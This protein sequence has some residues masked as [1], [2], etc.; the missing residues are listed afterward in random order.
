MNRDLPKE[1]STKENEYR[2]IL[3]VWGIWE[4]M[5]NRSEFPL[6]MIEILGLPILGI[7]RSLCCQNVR[8]PS[9]QIA[10][11]EEWWAVRLGLVLAPKCSGIQ[12]RHVS[13]KPRHH[14]PLFKVYFACRWIDRV[15]ALWQIN[16]LKLKVWNFE[17]AWGSPGES[18]TELVLLCL[19]LCEFRAGLG[20]IWG[21]FSN[22]SWRD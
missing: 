20:N 5:I 22:L 16:K 18:H 7:D 2:L 19:V 12:Y 3:N 8:L 17:D 14:F 15:S 13:A 11:L 10:G 6:P 1:A 9:W 21:F 4:G